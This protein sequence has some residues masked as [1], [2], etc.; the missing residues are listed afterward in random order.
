MKR[1]M[2]VK[3]PTFAGTKTAGKEVS[4]TTIS[5]SVQKEKLKE[6]R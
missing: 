2:N 1:K 6:V 3:T 5:S 4:Q